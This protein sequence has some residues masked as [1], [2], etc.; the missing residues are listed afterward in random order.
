MAPE[1]R[2]DDLL[3]ATRGRLLGA[4][5]TTAFSGASVDSRRITPGCCFVALAGERVDG[6]AFVADAFEAGATV[7]LVSRPVE[8]PPG[9]T[10]AIVQVGDPLR[11]LQDVAAWW[12]SRSPARVVGI[13]G[14]TGKTIAKE[15]IADVLSRT[16]CVLRSEG[17]LNSESG[18]PMTLL[19][20]GPE[21]DVAVLEMGMYTVGEIARLAE[22]ARPEVGVVMAV[23][24]THLLR[25]GSIER[26]AEGKSE[27]PRALPPDGLAVLNADDRHVAAMA[28]VTPAPVV[29]FGLGSAA[30]VQAR[31]VE[32]HGLAGTSF[33]IAA[34]WGTRRVT[35]ATPGRHLVPHAVAAAAVGERFGVSLDEV[36]AARATGSRAPH[37]M[38]IVRAA[39][40]TIVDDTYN[41]SP[42]SVIAA[43]DFLA[44]TP[45]AVGRRRLAVLGD[46]LELGPDEEAAH[47]RVGERAA[48]AVDGLVAV[49]ERGRWI[50]DAARHAGLERVA[51]AERVDD[52]VEA[53]WR[54]L[55]PGPGDM[56]LVKASRGIELDRLVDALSSASV[57]GG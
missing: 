41:A 29:T 38:A 57:A 36:E 27:L 28:A 5:T 52:G 50:A 32:T 37:R 49:G 21:H 22:I 6:H 56:L 30:D 45:L 25:A 33:T 20:L 46:M 19:R 1:I 7:A 24:P 2:L 13:T 48:R 17:N 35:S 8:R 10:A 51:E 55:A 34:P 23:H 4:T 39:G 18:L 16:L 14:S 15:M 12:A 47:R 54:T 26:V 44:E 43:L 3:N 31:D 9:S 42:V 40:L 11:A 53:V